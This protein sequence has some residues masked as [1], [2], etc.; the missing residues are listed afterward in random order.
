MVD[1]SH[2]NSGKLHSRQVEVARDVAAQLAGGQPLH[3]RRDGRE[4]PAGRRAE[5]RRRQGRSGA[6]SPT[7]RASP[8]PASAGTTRCARSRLLSD[9][10]AARRAHARGAVARAGLTARRS[11]RLQSRHARLSSRAVACSP[12]RR[13]R[14]RDRLAGDRARRAACRAMTDGPFYPSLAYR[15]RSLDW[16]ADLT[17]VRGRAPTA[18]RCRSARGEHLDLHG[19]VRRRR[20]P[21]RRR[22][23]GRDLAVRRVRQ[24]SP[25]ARRR[26]SHRRRLPGL[27]QRRAATR[28]AAT[29]SARSGRCRI[30]AA[31]RTSTSK[32]RHPGVR[33]GHVAAVRRRRAGQRRATSSIRASARAIARKSRCACSAAP[34]GDAGDVDRRARSSSS[35]PLSSR[36]AS[37]SAPLGAAASRARRSLFQ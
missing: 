5:V 12:R 30:R 14:R 21:R 27:R 24:L 20:R 18:S 15:A 9:A 19:A 16:D 23:R 28:A 7:A 34:A 10:V 29:A 31:R 32:L 37:Q 2:A 4:P 36:A 26:R 8:T 17:T 35:Q 33:R 25:S 11:T 3:L 1:C 13:R 22:R 6:S